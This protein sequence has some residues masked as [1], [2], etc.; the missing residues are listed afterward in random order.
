MKGQRTL[1]FSLLLCL[2][3]F[4]VIMSAVVLAQE[5][6]EQAAPAK[7]GGAQPKISFERADLTYD[8][9]T[10]PQMG[11]GEISIKFKNV[12][13]AD[14]KI[15]EI[16]SSCGCTVALATKD[17]IPP[18]QE[19]EIKA[20]LRVGKSKNSMKKAVYVET[21]DPD[22][23]KVTLFLVANVKIDFTLEPSFVSFGRVSKEELGQEQIIKVIGDDSLNYKLT[24]VESDNPA[25][26]ARILPPERDGEGQ[27]VALKLNQKV[28]TGILKGMIKIKSN[29]PNYAT[30]LVSVHGI[31]LG[32][33]QVDP[34]R[35]Y[36]SI[37]PGQD[38]EVKIVT[39]TNTERKDYKILA[40]KIEADPIHK[41]SAQRHALITYLEAKPDD[42]IMK[43]I[44]PD[45]SG[46]KRISFTLNRKLNP[47]E[48]LQGKVVLTT[49]DKTQEQVTI[50]FHAFAQLARNQEKTQQK[51]ETRTK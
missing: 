51:S 30:I 38:N 40:M 27:R 34:E 36:F 12:G 44:E 7:T 22:N 24:G 25:L 8:L 10:I 21:N 15:H 29:H 13:Q 1:L 16:K 48:R 4:C 49:D 32:H 19:G 2:I 31:I 6:G 18:G 23:K 33:I 47:G 5:K 28:S 41:S 35:L 50:V 26:E 11:Q 46:N 3:G 42:L 45:S 20:T 37:K 14:L 43:E 17:L 9:G 39:V